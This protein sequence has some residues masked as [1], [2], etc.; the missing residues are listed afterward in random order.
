MLISGE[1]GIGKSHIAE[2]MLARLREKPHVRLRYFCS[3]YHT[4]S[5]LYPFIAQIEQDAGFAPG[6]SVSLRLDR[7]EALVKPTATN[8][9]RDVAHFAELVG[10]P[11]DGR[12]PA[13]A[14]SPQQKRETTLGALLN[15]LNDA[16][17]RA[18]V[19]IVVRTRTGS[20]RRR[21]ICLSEW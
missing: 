11:M 17:S 8:L 19:L 9:P 2:S 4:H 21:W 15:R 1:P 3:P 20:I 18:P 16:A 6:D 5:A 13:L 10:V 14:V 7:L 12:Y